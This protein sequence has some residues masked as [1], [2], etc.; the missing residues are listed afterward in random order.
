MRSKNTPAKSKTTTMEKEQ[1]APPRRS[2][3]IETLAAAEA[4]AMHAD[5]L[6]S[7]KDYFNQ[8]GK[9]MQ[10]AED[11]EAAEEF[12][13]M[14][15]ER[16]ERT[17]LCCVM[18]EEVDDGSDDEE[19]EGEKNGDDEEEQQE[20]E[21]EQEDE[22]EEEDGDDDSDTDEDFELDGMIEKLERALKVFVPPAAAEALEAAQLTM[23]LAEAVP[24]VGPCTSRSCVQVEST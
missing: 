2:S 3:R 9:E 5:A 13:A 20:Q 10:A 6:A 8:M 4:E 1:P 18:L 7:T 14:I 22:E 16:E 12:A 24:G 17:G 19:E 23:T 21:E 15:Q 11:A